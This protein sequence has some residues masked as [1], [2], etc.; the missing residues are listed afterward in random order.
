M[1]STPVSINETSSTP[2]TSE[3]GYSASQGAD[4]SRY[5][6][7]RPI[8][9]P[10]FFARIYAYHAQKKQL[11]G[12]GGGWSVA[13]DV[14]AGCGIVAAGLASRF[15]RVM[16]SD[17]NEGYTE[18]ARTLLLGG[19]SS[20]LLDAKFRFLR[21][22]AEGGSSSIATASVDLVAACECIQ[23]TDADAAIAEFARQLRAGGTLAVTFYTRPNVVGHGEAAAAAWA[24]LVRARAP[25]EQG[26][27]YDAPYRIGNSGLDCLRFPAEDW[28]DVKRMY[29]N[30]RG[31]TGAF[32]LDDRVGE[33][34]VGEGEE[35]VWIEDEKDW[36]HVRGIDWFKGFFSTWVPYIPESKLRG[37][38]DDF[39]RALGGQK[40]STETPLVMIFATKRA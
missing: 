5:L 8:Y 16:V 34:R 3:F 2:P 22:R 10:S 1:S 20:S 21:E 27:E 15:E 33:A 35:Q 19:E 12:G 37:L 17:P 30:A 4:W 6:A 14:G 29:F 13:H 38:W 32:A 36:C 23:W 24:A 9:P 11:R 7:Y 18:L 25:H 26:P 40:V 31:S 39:E 28:V